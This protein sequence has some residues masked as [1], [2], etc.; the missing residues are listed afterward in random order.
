MKNKVDQITR[1][2]VLKNKL[3]EVSGKKIKFIKEDIK[4]SNEI[5]IEALNILIKIEELNKKISNIRGHLPELDNKRPEF[6]R[7]QAANVLLSKVIQSRL[8]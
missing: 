2:K 6:I 3:E 1:I 7:A 4:L 8:D 5:K